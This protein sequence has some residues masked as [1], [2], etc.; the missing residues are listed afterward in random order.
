M[1]N[2]HNLNPYLERKLR[3]RLRRG[4]ETI[5]EIILAL[6]FLPVIALVV[7]G[8]LIETG[9]RALLRSLMRSAKHDQR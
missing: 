8:I 3:E 5:A 9:V 1:V 7:I 2:D 4:G 6:L